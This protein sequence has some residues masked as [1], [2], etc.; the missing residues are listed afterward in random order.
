M[1]FVSVLFVLTIAAGLNKM[2]KT[3]EGVVVENDI[4]NKKAIK[5]TMKSVLSKNKVE[6]K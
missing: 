5:K 4:E 1:Y 2:R 3:K 6:N